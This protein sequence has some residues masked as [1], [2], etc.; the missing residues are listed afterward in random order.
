MELSV[1]IPT[2]NEAP[3]VAELVTRIEKA[4][5]GT[6][7]EILFVDD[8]T[9]DTPDVVTQVATEHEIPVRLLHR[10]VA[11]GGL[12]GAVIAGLRQ[13]T[14]EWA[15]VMDGDLQHRPETIP[16][17]LAQGR[18]TEADVVVASRHV[19]GGSSDGLSG[20]IR[21]A[22]S[23][24]SIKVTKA[25]FPSRLH[26]TTDPMSGFFGVRR[27]SVKL[28]GLHPRGFKILLEILARQP[29]EIREVPL[30][31]DARLAGTSKADMKQ[32]IALGRQLFDL[33][34]GRISGFA[35]IGALGAVANLVILWGLQQFG[36]GYLAAA[37]IAAVVTIIGNFLLQERFIFNDLKAGARGVWKRWWHTFAFNG[38]ESAIRTF[39]LWVI[40]ENTNLHSVLVQAG[41]IVI[42]F[43]L[44]FLYQ[45]RVVYKQHEPVVTIDDIVEGEPTETAPAAT[46][47]AAV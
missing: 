19:D 44:R 37:C 43:S 7:A 29:L 38:T 21:R 8:S 47:P 1:V 24:L 28:D 12:S 42:G 3:N 26:G 33:K 32:G 31:F 5:A 6:D 35:A 15:V 36:V 18:A 20:G 2:F 41:L 39:A 40:V 25:L 30:V 13:A 23:Q 17:V 16:S 34:F 46:T 27:D 22:V 11:V 9:D 45:S 4:V 10:D 14:G